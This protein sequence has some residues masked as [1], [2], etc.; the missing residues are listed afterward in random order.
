MKDDIAVTVFYLAPADL[1]DV[2]FVADDIAL[3]DKYPEGMTVVA[4]EEPFKV[5]EIRPGLNVP[6][7]FIQESAKL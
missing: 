7:W 3:T 2:R 6:D 4:I 1:G 5:L